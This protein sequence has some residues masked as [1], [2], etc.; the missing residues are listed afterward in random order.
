M[1]GEKDN[2]QRGRIEQ[3]GDRRRTSATKISWKG[4][5]R[6]EGKRGE[7]GTVRS[8]GS[9]ATG[10]QT[11]APRFSFVH[12][13]ARARVIAAALLR[14][15]IITRGAYEGKGKGRMTRRRE[16]RCASI[17]DVRTLA[18]GPRERALWENFVIAIFKF[19]YGKT[20]KM[21]LMDWIVNSFFSFILILYIYLP[22]ESWEHLMKCPYRW[23]LNLL[24]YLF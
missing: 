13:C 4:E 18:C 16:I 17:D 7:A 14:P 23:N 5:G 21:K 20:R 19:R 22:I 6:L 12:V 10:K 15:S 11:S 8:H 24:M 9:A 3:A 2:K 1:V